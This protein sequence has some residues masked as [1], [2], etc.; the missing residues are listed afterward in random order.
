[1]PHTPFF[2]PSKTIFHTYSNI[3]RCGIKI[4][5]KLHLLSHF[6]F[7]FHRTVTIYVVGYFSF[8]VLGFPIFSMLCFVFSITAIN[9]YLF[10]VRTHYLSA[11]GWPLS[12]GFNFVSG[13]LGAS[14]FFR[15]IFTFYLFNRG[16]TFF[17]QDLREGSNFFIARFLWKKPTRYVNNVS[18]LSKET[19]FM[20]AFSKGSCVFL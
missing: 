4:H 14:D 1:V 13:N 10:L 9:R 8:D 16:F 11:G 15:N 2:R 5:K 12:R 17:S 6:V 3:V 7:D 18:S 19:L 20:G